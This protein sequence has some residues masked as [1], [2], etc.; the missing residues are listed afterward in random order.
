LTC[1]GIYAVGSQF[2][3]IKTPSVIINSWTFSIQK[4]K[5]KIQLFQTGTTQYIQNETYSKEKKYNLLTSQ[6][7][8]SK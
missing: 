3:F 8:K 7:G 4:K 5:V 6:T 1:C 2:G